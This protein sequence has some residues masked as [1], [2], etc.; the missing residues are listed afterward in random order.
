MLG[1]RWSVELCKTTIDVL[2]GA[3]F[4]AD[5]LLSVDFMFA[6]YNQDKIIV[7]RLISVQVSDVQ[8]KGAV[9]KWVVD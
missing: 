8:I 3:S 5:G 1:F 9:N 2:D 7:I 4:K 6:H